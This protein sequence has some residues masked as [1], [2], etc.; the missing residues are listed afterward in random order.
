[1]CSA[2]VG[3][4]PEVFRG[5]TAHGRHASFA[6]AAARAAGLVLGAVA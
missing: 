2:E 1:M 6:G 4:L 5:S 3:Q